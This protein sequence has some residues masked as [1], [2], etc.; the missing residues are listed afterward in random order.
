MDQSEFELQL[1]IWKDLAISKQVL[2]SAAADALGLDPDCNTNELKN[3]LDSIIE[4]SRNADTAIKKAEE[5]AHTAIEAMEQKIKH[6]EQITEEILTAKDEAEAAC[7]AAEQRVI[8]ARTSNAEE[9]KKIK[10]QLADEQKKLKTINTSLGDTPEN[11]IKKLKTLKKQKMDSTSAQKR[12]EEATRSIRKEK[13]ILEQRLENIESA[14][15][16]C[17]KMADQYRECHK[18]CSTMHDLLKD[19][20]DRPKLPDLNENLLEDIEEASKS[21]EKESHLSS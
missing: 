17:S 4:R 19:S 8:A 14:I 9:I 2:M 10:K 18:V 11:V 5:K 21:L 6:S 3:A 7:K 15:K 16:N 13:Q 20:D 1:Q 12:L